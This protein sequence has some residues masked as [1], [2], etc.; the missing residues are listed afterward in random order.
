MLVLHAAYL[1]RSLDTGGAAS[2]LHERAPFVVLAGSLTSLF[3]LR[4]LTTP[5]RLRR[6][7]AACFNS[8]VV[9]AVPDLLGLLTGG[10]VLRGLSWDSVASFRDHAERID[11]YREDAGSPDLRVPVKGEAQLTQ[12]LELLDSKGI[13]RRE[14]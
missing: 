7:R 13:P 8:G 5:L 2:W 10:A 14:D 11:L 9:T 3:L 6:A 12:L 1:Q 4:L